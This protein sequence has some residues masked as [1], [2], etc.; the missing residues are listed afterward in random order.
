MMFAGGMPGMQGMPGMRIFHNGVQV[1]VSQMQRPE[2]IIKNVQL[3]MEQCFCGCI[4]PV[5]IERWV[6]SNN[7]KITETET[8]TI[9]IPPGL[10]ENEVVILHDKGHRA[11]DTVIGEVR[12]QIHITNNTDFQRSGLDLIYNKSISLKEA[13]CGFSFEIMH[14][15]GKKMCINNSTF[16]II[17]PNYNK[18]IPSLGMTRDNTTGNMVIVF[19]VI[20]PDTLTPE[21]IATIS[22]VL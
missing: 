12:L 20:F 4:I 17:K 10:N 16:T 5:E 9:S 8:I 18:I 13:L 6:I 14:V 19:N 2:P 3:T 15:N 11:N 1:N 21:Q 7:V 22:S